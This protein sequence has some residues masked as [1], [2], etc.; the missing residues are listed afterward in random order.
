ML[1]R[2]NYRLFSSS[3]VNTSSTL[4]ATEKILI[5]DSDNQAIGHAP[6]KEMREKNLWHRSS[7]IF[8]ANYQK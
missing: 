2:R 8:V 1:L 7:T 6:R 5:I 3:T 4:S